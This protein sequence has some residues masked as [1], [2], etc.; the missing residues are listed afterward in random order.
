MRILC[1]FYAVINKQD[2]DPTLKTALQVRLMGINRS[3]STDSIFQIP[4]VRFLCISYTR[5]SRNTLT[6]VDE[7]V[8]IE[9]IEDIMWLLHLLLFWQLKMRVY[10]VG[11]GWQTQRKG[12]KWQRPLPTHCTAPAR[13]PPRACEEQKRSVTKN[14]A[15]TFQHTSQICDCARTSNVSD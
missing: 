15:H 10:T 1:V 7:C 3:H 9:G 6:S 8:G 14:V 12:S 2:S 13:Y 4:Q 5:S 11:K